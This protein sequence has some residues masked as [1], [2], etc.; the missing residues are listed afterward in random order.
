VF[1]VNFTAQGIERFADLMPKD[2]LD[3]LEQTAREIRALLGGL[4]ERE[5]PRLTAARWGLG[6]LPLRAA[7]LSR[8]P[9]AHSD[10]ETV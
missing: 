1:E 7:D 10:K 4:R 9:P 6:G 3:T 5:R 8:L 2:T